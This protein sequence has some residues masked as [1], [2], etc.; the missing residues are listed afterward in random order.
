MEDHAIVE[1]YWQRSDSA[2]PETEKKYGSY[3]HSIAY[4]ICASHE[5][6]EECVNDTWLK[7]WNQMPDKRPRLL[8]VFLGGITR[9]FA[10]DRYRSDTRQKRGGGETALALDE[11]AGCIPAAEDTES[12]FEVGELERAIDFFTASLPETE[13]R[14]FLARYWFVL[15][16]AEIAA[17][18]DMSQSRVKSSLF[19]M[20]K[21]LRA[22]L[23]EEGLF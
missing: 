2:I 1:L 6:A 22:F 20:R 14:M 13:R 7:A 9:N 15:P 4:G 12:L 16:V 18:L 21:R 8:S 10:I 5:D 23:K 3:C 17:R 11:L 19:R